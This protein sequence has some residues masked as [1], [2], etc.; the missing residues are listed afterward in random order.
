MTSVSEDVDKVRS[1]YSAGENIK[2]YSCYGQ[3]FGSS[4]LKQLPFNPIIHFKAYTQKP[5]LYVYINICT[6][7]F[8][9]FKIIQKGK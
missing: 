6:P 7:V 8:I 9:S 3:Q 1:S 2:W 5:K 4:T